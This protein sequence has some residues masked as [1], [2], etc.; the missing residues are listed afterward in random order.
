MSDGEK[1]VEITATMK[2]KLDKLLAQEEKQ[3]R[4][5]QVL[6]AKLTLQAKWARL[7]GCPVDKKH[8][9]F[10]LGV[11]EQIRDTIP[12]IQ[13]IAFADAWDEKTDATAHAVEMLGK[14]EGTE[15]PSLA[16]ETEEEELD[17]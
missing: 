17:A 6:N 15:E 10:Y 1:T 16:D 7:N 4:Y 2:A 11:D 14:K 3:K 5:Q 13:L 9:E 8:A 12:V